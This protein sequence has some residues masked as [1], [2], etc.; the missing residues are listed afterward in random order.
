MWID[1]L[2]KHFLFFFRPCDVLFATEDT[3]EQ[4]ED[5]YDQFGDSYSHNAT[6]DSLKYSINQV[7]E[8]G[9]ALED[10]TATEIAQFE[11]EHRD[12]FSKNL[13]LAGLFRA[14]TASFH[15]DLEISSLT[16]RFYGGQVEKSFIGISYYFVKSDDYSKEDLQNIKAKRRDLQGRKTFKILTEDWID[17]CI[18]KKTLISETDYEL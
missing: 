7:R 11:N 10:L 13:K 6:L 2:Y 3:N 4:F 17:D 9:E 5:Y 1:I 8:K 16:F 18:E 15:K 12:T 14:L